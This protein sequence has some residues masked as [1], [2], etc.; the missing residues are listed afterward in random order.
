MLTIEALK[1]LEQRAVA[2]AHPEI[3]DCGGIPYLVLPDGVR[4]ESLERFCEAPTRFRGTFKTRRTSDF[5]AYV[6]ANLSDDGLH[7]PIFVDPDTMQ[8]HAIFGLGHESRPGW[9]EHSAALVLQEDPAYSALLKRQSTDENPRAFSQLQFLDF[10]ADWRK[11]LLF[12]IEG[13]EVAPLDHAAVVKS[14]R[15]LSVETRSDEDS[16]VGN[17][18]AA[19]TTMESVDI[20]A[21]SGSILPGRFEFHCKPYDEFDERRIECQLRSSVTASDKTVRLMYRIMGLER[22][23]LA[24]ADEFVTR[25]SSGFKSAGSQAGYDIRIGTFTKGKP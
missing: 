13:D 5:V 3:Q 22:L 21:R 20:R 25:L 15:S 12:F 24:I 4:A 6:I 17:F 7:T 9:G 1:H 10:I 16:T 19:R 14:V 23:R 18:N 8:A 11:D 2:S